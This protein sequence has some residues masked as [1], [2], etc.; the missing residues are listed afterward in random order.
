MKSDAIKEE[1][2]SDLHARRRRARLL[3]TAER[4]ME[5]G[6]LWHLTDA[7][8]GKEKKTEESRLFDIC[9]EQCHESFHYAPAF[10]YRS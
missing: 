6:A 2:L 4:C 5:C 3:D 1:I 7:P 8:G 10:R 9:E